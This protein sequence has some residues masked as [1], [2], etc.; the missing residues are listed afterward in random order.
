MNAIYRLLAE[1]FCMSN[2]DRL[3]T[4]FSFKTGPAHTTLTWEAM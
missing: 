3:R 4:A 2:A 1:P